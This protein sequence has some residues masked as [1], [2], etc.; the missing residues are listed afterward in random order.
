[1]IP[2]EPIHEV[3]LDTHVLIWAIKGIAEPTQN[4]E[5]I[6]SM[7][8]LDNLASTSCKLNISS[9][10]I[11]ESLI[12]IEKQEQDQFY[13]Q[14]EANFN[15]LSFNPAVARTTATIIQEMYPTMKE[16]INE[17][18]DGGHQHARG[19]VCNDMKII[20]T[21]AY[22]NIDT[23]CTNDKKMHKLAKPYVKN[24]LHPT[25]LNELALYHPESFKAKKS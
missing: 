3:L 1:M 18:R 11:A 25:E 21:A 17:L 16:F 10:S 13:K 14:L 4:K 5:I 6:A 12:R 23:I 2:Q 9:I 24:I 19:I 20:G 22:R 8:L 15:F 7:E